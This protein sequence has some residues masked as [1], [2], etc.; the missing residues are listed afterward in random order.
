MDALLI[1]VALLATAACVAAVALYRLRLRA[2]AKFLRE[3]D[4]LSNLRLPIEG[5]LP[6]TTELT[7][8]INHE[9][10]E[11]AA[12]R[13]EQQQTE[14]EFQQNLAS[15]SHDIRTPLAGAKGYVQL[16]ADEE[17]AAVCT[18]YLQAAATRLEDMQGLLDQLLSYARSED[19][20]ELALEPMNA[21]LPLAAVLAAKHPE[22]QAHEMAVQVE[23]G[24][25]PLF[26]LVD[27]DVLRRIYEN[28]I[29]NA[30]IH[31]NGAL[32]VQ[33]AGDGLTFANPLQPGEQPDPACVFERFYR[34]D[35]ARGRTGA[36]LGLAV[37][38][39]LCEVQGIS[40]TAAVQDGA[41]VL[42]LMF[43]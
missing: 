10:D 37:V 17:D 9:L 19:Q 32:T 16:A 38:R 5:A 27:E 6:G 34:E 25:E 35:A 18:R 14:A 8:A 13:Q 21:L 2:M 39:N 36:G 23:L 7:R 24:E 41:F 40:V 15:L 31:G 26:A 42:K 1:I 4:R 28:V 29:Q 30:L 12:E 33:R 3:R 43:P 20:T 22:C 11:G